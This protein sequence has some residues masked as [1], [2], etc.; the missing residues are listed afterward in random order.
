LVSRTLKGYESILA[1]LHFFRINRS[2]LVNLKCIKIV[3]RQRSPTVT[4]D[5][6]TELVMSSFRKD[7]FFK[8]MGKGI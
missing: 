7:E 5:D 4:L 3:G 1:D 6:G 8:K 2:Q